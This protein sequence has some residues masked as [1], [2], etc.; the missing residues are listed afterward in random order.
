MFVLP[1]P[2]E[3]LDDDRALHPHWRRPP[4]GLERL[5]QGLGVLGGHPGGLQR[6]GDL[7]SGEPVEGFKVGEAEFAVGVET[8]FKAVDSEM[9]VFNVE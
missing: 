7:L 1:S 2:A 9:Q 4:P 8:L 5:Q 6:G 3:M